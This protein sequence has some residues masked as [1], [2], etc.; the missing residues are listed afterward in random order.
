MSVRRLIVFQTYTVAIVNELRPKTDS[1]SGGFSGALPV[2]I[3]IVGTG[4]GVMAEFLAGNLTAT[5]PA[6]IGINRPSNCV[7]LK[8]MFSVSPRRRN[9]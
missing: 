2:P 6:R 9:I 5:A 8:V 4:I 7:C 3:A 1:G